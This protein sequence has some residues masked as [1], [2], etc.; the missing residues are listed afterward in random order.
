MGDGIGRPIMQSRQ[1]LELFNG[2]FLGRDAQFVIQLAD[3]RIFGTQHR[4]LGHVVGCIHL[5][6]LH[7]V[8]RMGA[9]RVGPDLCETDKKERYTPVSEETTSF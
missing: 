4:S 7:A 1:E 3:G 8:K 9:A 6:G 5:G 2:Q